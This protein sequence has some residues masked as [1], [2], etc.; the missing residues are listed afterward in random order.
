MSALKKPIISE[1]MTLQ[2][3]RPGQ[4]QY[5]FRVDLAA[6]KP[7]IKREIEH[8]YGVNVKSVRTLV[9]AGKKRTR[10]TRTGFLSGK[11]SNYKKAIVTLAPGEEIDFYKNI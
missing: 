4:K 2:N 3:E 10:Y 5:A 9:V 7:E 1:K 8:M 6:A 11:S